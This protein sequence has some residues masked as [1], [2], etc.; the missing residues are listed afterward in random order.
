MAVLDTLF[1]LLSY[2]SNLE[3]WS[4]FQ[5]ALP[6]WP[7]KNQDL[8]DAVVS[9][10]YVDPDTGLDACV[11]QRVKSSLRSASCDYLSVKDICP[12]LCEFS[13]EGALVLR[14]RV[15]GIEFEVREPD[16]VDL[17]ELRDRVRLWDR[18]GVLQAL[19]EARM[20]TGVRKFV[21]TSAGS[22]LALMGAL[23]IC[24]KEVLRSVLSYE[25]AHSL[26]FSIRISKLFTD[27]GLDDGERLFDFIFSILERLSPGFRDLTFVGLLQK[28]GNELHIPTTCVTTGSLVLMSADTTPD[29]KIATAIRAS[30]SI[31]LIFTSPIID[32]KRFCDGGLVAYNPVSLVSQ[33]PPE[34]KLAILVL[35]DYDREDVNDVL[36][37]TARVIRLVCTY[38]QLQA[39]E[40]E[41]WVFSSTST[42]GMGVTIPDTT[43]M[44]TDFERGRK[45]AGVYLLKRFKPKDKLD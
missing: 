34:E 6:A 24:P 13:D 26:L 1:F 4:W 20:L 39:I 11:A 33:I 32:D 45:E 43:A 37:F 35:P 15:G 9:A 42:D 40:R 29:L 17:N 36:A 30:C 38:H 2:I 7:V 18:L 19:R 25:A 41:D 31:P 21:G 8:V 16:L 10:H 14:C 5:S 27:F 44:V 23:N 12:E 28:T 3:L 22:I